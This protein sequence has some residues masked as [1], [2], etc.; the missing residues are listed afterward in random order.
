[1]NSTM[2]H[3]L[4]HAPQDDTHFASSLRVMGPHQGLL[5][6]ED[7]VY[8][9]L[10]RTSSA[11]AMQLLPGSVGLYALESDVQARGLP[12]DDLPR[13]VMLIDYPQMVELC[14]SHD[15]VLSW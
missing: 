4:R 7:A 1:M 11:N 3:I 15:K 6:I 8:A 5:L 2:L 12:I 13:R 9:L 10:P 14:I